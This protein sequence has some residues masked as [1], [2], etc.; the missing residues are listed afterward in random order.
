[1]KKRKVQLRIIH[2]QLDTLN[3][4]PLSLCADLLSTLEGNQRHL[5]IMRCFLKRDLLM[6]LTKKNSV[7]HKKSD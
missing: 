3:D 6:R 1:M 7:R 4:R 5:K 2:G